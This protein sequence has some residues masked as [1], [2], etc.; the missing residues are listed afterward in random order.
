MTKRI[1]VTEEIAETGLNRLRHAGFEVDV[2]LGVSGK[3]FYMA[4]AGAHG[5]IVRSATQVDAAALDA[6]G[7]LV[8]VARAG[9]G[10]DNIDVQAATARGVM[11]V[12]A[13]E[14]NVLSA[15]EHTIGLM[16]ALARNIPQAH[17]ALKF[18]R[19]ERS[20]WEGIELAGKTLGIIGLGRIGKLVAL[21]A[22]AFNMC[23]VG[24]DPFI[25]EERARQLNV[26]MMPLDQVIALADFLTVHLPKN[27]ETTGMINYDVL[28][29]AKPTLRI[30]NVARGGIIDETDLLAAL[31]DGRIAGAALDVF[32]TEPMTSSPLFELDN[33]VVTPHLGAST[34]EA[35]DRAG[36]VVADMVRLALDGEFVP[37]AVNIAASEM[38]ETLNPF[39]PLAERLGRVFASFIGE[40]PTD[41]E[42]ISSGEIG[43]CDSQI[44]TLNALKGLL[45]VLSTE[46]VSLIN[47]PLVAKK[48]G[49][50]VHQAATPTTTHHDYVN[51]ITLR[52]GERNMSAT[53]AGRRREARIVTVNDH[54]TDIPP[55]V[56]MLVVTNDD[57][58]GVIG[59]VGTL[60]GNA[61]INISNM[62]VGKTERQGSAIM[63]IAMSSGVPDE[64]VTQLRAL[65]G[66]VSVATI[67]G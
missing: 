45:S 66:I 15:A 38:N 39:V 51:L 10:L 4:L 43:A 35:Q 31:R 2:Q 64:L 44:I 19:W 32:S 13:P 3:E 29:T 22:L 36:E 46:N 28:R 11:V 16:L 33:V 30:I 8:V 1:L 48:L 62:D 65:P 18:G 53:L 63:M 47:A 60:L 56:H 61:N 5:L 57:R 21:R 17:S 58:P 12:N 26:K 54:I 14:S 67:R 20:K 6:G 27:R 23:L 34:R 59:R 9:A 41:F 55:S 42:V 50:K 7:D 52:A 49:I 40:I 24:Y 25:S 37:F